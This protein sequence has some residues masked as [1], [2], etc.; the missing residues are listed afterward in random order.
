MNL[1]KFYTILLILSVFS[2]TKLSAVNIDSLISAKKLEAPV[3]QLK[4]SED[5]IYS[6]HPYQNENTYS[7]IFELEKLD[8]NIWRQS[9]SDTSFSWNYF[10]SFYGKDG[11]IEFVSSFLLA[12][13]VQFCFPE[14]RIESVHVVDK[15]KYIGLFLRVW[16]DEFDI[17]D[18]SYTK[19][20]FNDLQLSEKFYWTSLFYW[21][22][23]DLAT[24][25]WFIWKHNEK[26]ESRFVLPNIP[27]FITGGDFYQKNLAINDLEIKSFVSEVKGDSLMQMKLDQ[28]KMI[29]AQ[30]LMYHKSLSVWSSEITDFLNKEGKVH[31][32]KWKMSY[33]KFKRRI[34]NHTHHINQKSLKIKDEIK[35]KYGDHVV[36]T[37][38]RVESFQGLLTLNSVP[39]DSMRRPIDVIKDVPVVLKAQSANNWEFNSWVNRLE[40]DTI[41][42][43]IIEIIPGEVEKLPLPEFKP[44]NVRSYRRIVNKEHDNYFTFMYANYYYGVLSILGLIILSLGWSIFKS[45]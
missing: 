34:E 3:Y 22:Q 8:S 45:K 6:L 24:N 1:N 44:L 17:K 35:A 4:M 39:L 42:D 12:K 30:T 25:D 23:P 16:L 19:V 9:I 14:V 26:Q 27:F 5:S 29:W 20:D 21:F 37:N 36:L 7:G 28:N 31:S 18:Y 41:T 40:S 15:D 33:S 32:R 38:P 2:L 10:V 43:R 11:D 13:M